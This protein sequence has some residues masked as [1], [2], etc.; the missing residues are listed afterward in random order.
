MDQVDET[1]DPFIGKTIAGKYRITARIGSGGMSGIY[2]AEHSFM[3]RD[4]ALKIL[5]PQLAVDPTSRRR[6]EH[7]AKIASQI[8][9]PNAVILFDFGV[10]EDL[11]FLVMELIEGKTLKEVTQEGARLP[12]EKIAE[13]NDQVCGALQEAHGLGIIHRDVKPTNIMLRGAAQRVKVLDFGIAKVLNNPL[14][15]GSDLTIAGTIVGTPHYMSPE[16]GLCKELDPRSDIYSLG[17]VLYE[18]ICG[19]RPFDAPSTLELLVKHVNTPPPPLRSNPNGAYV[20]PDVEHV[21]MKCLEKNPADRFQSMDELADA[22][23]SAVMNP[24]SSASLDRRRVKIAPLKPRG[25]FGPLQMALLVILITVPL[26]YL[27][28]RSRITSGGSTKI[29]STTGSETKNGGDITSGTSGNEGPANVTTVPAGP[30]PRMF[31]MFMEDLNSKDENVRYR[32]AEELLKIGTPEATT[33]VD[34]FRIA[35]E[36]RKE[37]LKADEEAEKQRQAEEQKKEEARLAE[38]KRQDEEA[39]RKLKELEFQKKQLE[40]L[41][42][43]A[44]EERILAEKKAE[45]MKALA[46]RQADD[47]RRNSAEKAVTEKAAAEKAAAEK[48][49][50]VKQELERANKRIQDQKIED[51]AR[52]ERDEADRQR[53]EAER[54]QREAERAARAVTTT[55]PAAAT[56]AP[57]DDNP[58]EGQKKKRKR[59]GPNWCM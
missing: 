49:E 13:I 47:A 14:S 50:A 27:G 11:P 44:E 48:A 43:K 33:A 19:E 20:S 3:S 29:S 35:E 2:R 15:Q 58:D 42:R 55:V 8:N 26:L 21:V 5:P 17:V 23:R 6:F 22:F 38:Q 28:F 4:V 7:E 59:C 56:V 25:K 52:R 30:D 46:E 34:Q 18:L 57:S 1:N 10:D 51:Q 9:H 54:R 24:G 37:Q 45:E 41:A 53:R 16:Q 39:E 32:A 36:K 31:K 12:L 40:E